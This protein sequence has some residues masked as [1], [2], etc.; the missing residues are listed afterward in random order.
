MFTIAITEKKWIDNLKSLSISSGTEIN[1][2]TPTPWNV[3]LEPNSNF[4]FLLKSP[5]RKVCGKANF[6]R[7][8]NKKESDAWNEFK[9]FNGMNSFNEMQNQLN[10]FRAKRSVRTYSDIGCIILNKVELWDDYIDLNDYGL[11][12]PTQ[13][14][15]YKKFN[16][17]SMPIKT[18]ILSKDIEEIILDKTISATEREVLIAARIGQGKY[19][20]DLE[21]L[22][23]SCSVTGYS[24][25]EFLI[26]SHIKPWRDS[27]N[28]ERLDK[29]NGLLLTPNL[30]KLFDKGHISFQNDGKIVISKNLHE[31]DLKALNID[32]NMSINPKKGNLKYLKFHRENIFSM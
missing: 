9:S 1:F 6:L 15:K 27:S 14:V 13:I 10:E 2:W 5:I 8:E 18:D 21:E 31:K 32:K 3:K 19:K 11:S 24:N 25:L 16:G 22:W 20:S 30:D 26:A 23:K 4:Y 12:F 29:F 28:I 7:Y 17:N